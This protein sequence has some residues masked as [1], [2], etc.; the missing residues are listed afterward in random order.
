MRAQLEVLEDKTYEKVRKDGESSGVSKMDR[1]EKRKKEK[2]EGVAAC[3]HG[4]RYLL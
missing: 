3:R 1:R 4:M 2:D